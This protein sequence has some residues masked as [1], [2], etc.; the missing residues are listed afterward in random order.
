MYDFDF[1]KG[2]KKEKEKKEKEKF[3]DSKPR[4]FPRK[5]PRQKVLDILWQK[6]RYLSLT[7][8]TFGSLS[9]DINTLSNKYS[10]HCPTYSVHL[11]LT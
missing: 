11:V 10:T 5:W 2:R 3:S 9:S 7:N 4:H 1:D 6:Q 8:W